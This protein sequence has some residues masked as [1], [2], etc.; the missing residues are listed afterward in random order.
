MNSIKKKAF[1]TIV[2]FALVGLT[3]FTVIK[4]SETFSL[5]G[6]VKYVSG[7][8]LQWIVL[9]FVCMLGF[10]VFE[11][12]AVLVLGRA[13]G[14]KR[15]FKRGLVYSVT[16]IY[17]SAIT[18]SATGGQPAS[19]YFMMKDKIPGAVT[20]IILLTNLT[21]YTISIIVIGSVCLIT[22]PGMIANFSVVSKCMI[23]VGFCFQFVMLVAFVLLVYKEK[24]VMKI[25]DTAMRVLSKL[26][27]IRNIE[28]K[29][30]RLKE[31]EK[32]YK[33]CAN[34][35]KYHKKSIFVAFICNLLQRISQIMVSV[36]VFIAVGGNSSQIFDAFAAQGYVVLGSNSV[37]IPGAVGAADYLFIDG[38]GS[39]V[40]DTV[41]V[42]LLS[43]GISFYS[44]IIIC[45]IITIIVYTSEGLK[46]IKRK[47]KC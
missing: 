20:T 12:L 34:A 6:F 32:Q 25:A 4:Q 33:E 47:K 38:F 27:L 30:A 8:S 28:K 24:I 35:I 17:F 22:R 1:W 10:I 46:G 14:Y 7:A 42:E 3:L 44:C 21:L 37:P 23:A 43:R 39:L 45:G 36:C 26:H 29:Q 16:D 9:A 41:S 18:P 19:A 31:V 15:K 5:G 2:F 13:F 40:K 11:G